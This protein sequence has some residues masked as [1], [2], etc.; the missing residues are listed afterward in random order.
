MVCLLGGFST[1]AL[2]A[3]G[4]QEVNATVKIFDVPVVLQ[5]PAVVIDEHLYVPLRDV[6]VPMQLEVFFDK[7]ADE[8][9]VKRYPD[10][11]W[12]V[13]SV[14]AR[15]IL[16]N[17][18]QALMAVPPLEYAGRV[19][20]P[21]GQFAWLFGLTMRHDKQGHYVVSN[22]LV[23]ISVEKDHL[24]FETSSPMDPES[25]FHQEQSQLIV[26]FPHTVLV[27]NNRVIKGAGAL[28]KVFVAQNQLLPDLTR[29]SIKLG[30][31]EGHRVVTENAHKRWTLY[32]GKVPVMPAKTPDLQIAETQE[33]T[34]QV[35]ASTGRYQESTML[36][37]WLPH[38]ASQAQIRFR[39]KQQEVA[40]EP[41][42]YDGE[43]LMFPAG[44]VL[45]ALGYSVYY[46][47]GHHSTEIT[48]GSGRTY[49]IRDGSSELLIHEARQ[50]DRRLDL[51]IKAQ[52]VGNE[53]YL[54]L[55]P[56]FRVL[57]E[58]AKWD[59][60]NY[61][62]Q[63]NPVI[64]EML[65]EDRQGRLQI[66]ALAESELDAGQAGQAR[67]PERLFVDIPNAYVDVPKTSFEVD[68]PHISAVRI[69]QFDPTTVRLAVTLRR[70][71]SYALHQDQSKTV[72]TLQFV[73]W[74][75][76]VALSGD[77]QNSRLVIEG[78]GQVPYVFTE[79][80]APRRYAFD[81][82][83]VLM[84]TEGVELTANDL[85]QGAE[86]SQWS[87]DPYIGRLILTVGPQARIVRDLTQARL[88]FMVSRAPDE[89]GVVASAPK[90]ADPRRTKAPSPLNGKRIVIEAG[91]GGMD[92]GSVGRR[93]TFES[94]VTLATALY[95]KELLESEG[96]RVL[97]PRQDDRFMSLSQRV[98]Y[99]NRL[100][101]D[102]FISVHYN[103]HD[104]TTLRGTET[105]YYKG[106][107][108]GLARA[109]HRSMLKE[110]KL[111][112][113]GIRKAGFYVL[114][115]TRAPA[116]CVEPAYLSNLHEESLIRRPGFQR[117]VAQAVVVGLK[118]YYKSLTASR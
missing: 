106:V 13:F 67:Q 113:N 41:P 115:H 114:N 47:H 101:A 18:S 111:P 11:R 22:R 71:I 43:T 107:D 79:L 112:D 84:K 57:G 118:D 6:A 87:V 15:E 44:A 83:G 77:A 14:A 27:G 30:S 91:H 17:D 58:G 23:Q 46:D 105:F 65:L 4:P 68:L 82:P 7:R 42:H 64:H 61:T 78:T 28:G 10:Q 89:Q 59:A 74:V 92:P 108:Y 35:L 60:Q 37:L 19:Y 62:I 34:S 97:L 55:V 31:Y 85:V 2:A 96:A 69:A 49:S 52:S 93:G 38:L 25:W 73:P 56:L 5:S 98:S 20:V 9:T 104:H 100:M 103:S 3:R 40:K 70:D 39:V 110:L 95:L 26:D 116:V 33:T 102:A 80:Q 63:I 72:Q 54:P 45:S 66:S 51:G 109:V 32:L 48:R 88:T 50:L 8:Y 81:F 76:R 12:M 29:I 16:V 75:E 36:V 21:L 1:L 86:V 94:N 117:Q 24:V 53:T 90:S 99:S